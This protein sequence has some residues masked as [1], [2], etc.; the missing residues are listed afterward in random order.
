MSLASGKENTL[1]HERR[2]AVKRRCSSRLAVS[3]FLLGLFS[4]PPF[5][6][7]EALQEWTVVNPEGVIAVTPM[8]DIKV[9]PRP[10]TLEGKTVMLHWNGKPNGDHVLDRVAE[11]LSKESKGVKILK[12]WQVAP[13]TAMNSG[14]PDVSE[15]NV[16]T[17]AKYKPDLVIGSQAD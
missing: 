16:A 10:A 8:G 17:M 4:I 14:K 7:A 9:N 2:F 12:N 13:E 6:F 15:K 11:L 1:A 5:A 3:V